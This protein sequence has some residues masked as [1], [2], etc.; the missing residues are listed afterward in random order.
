MSSSSHSDVSSDCPLCFFSAFSKPVILLTCDCGFGS[1]DCGNFGFSLANIAWIIFAVGAP[2]GALGTPICPSA[3]GAPICPDTLG[4]PGG[5]QPGG[6]GG[7]G[8]GAPPINS[9]FKFKYF[10]LYFKYLSK[11]AFI[12]IY[13]YIYI[14][15]KN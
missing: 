6:G 7:G 12:Y 1:C 13:I 5:C 10:D 4:A 14:Y 8:G 9:F 3:L 11:L 15:I 2:P